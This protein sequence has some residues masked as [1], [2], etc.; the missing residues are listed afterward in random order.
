MC[1]VSVFTFV[2]CWSC[3][4]FCGVQGDWRWSWTATSTDER[5]GMALQR[6]TE[7]LE[8]AEAWR[9]DWGHGLHHDW[10]TALHGHCSA[11]CSTAAL[12]DMCIDWIECIAVYR[13]W[14]LCIG[15]QLSRT[16]ARADCC[17]SFVFMWSSC[18]AWQCSAAQQ[19]LI[20]DIDMEKYTVSLSE[21]QVPKGIRDQERWQGVRWLYVASQ[22]DAS[23][24]VVR[25]CMML[26]VHMYNCN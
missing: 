14:F 19:V 23:S 4:C 9:G 21:T 1:W 2:P 5:P 24:I 16:L 22:V 7:R 25:C 17:T 8:A 15:V 12:Y 6:V 26:Y 13:S 11:H 3:C 10:S 18:V 20:V